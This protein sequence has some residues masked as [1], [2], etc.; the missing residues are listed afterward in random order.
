MDGIQ[1]QVSA[2]IQQVFI[3]L[4]QPRPIAALRQVTAALV[5]FIKIHRVGCNQTAHEVA[6][7]TKRSL[8]Q[9]VEMI[10]HEAK[11]IEAHSVGLHSPCQALQKP[12]PVPIVHENDLPGI[13]AY[14]HVVDRPSELNA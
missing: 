2:Q 3:S 13:A 11:Q 5:A 6:E 12:F 7:V 9:Q 10:R 14:R 4:H 8:H 1:V